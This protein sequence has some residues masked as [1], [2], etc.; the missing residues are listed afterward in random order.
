MVNYHIDILQEYVD[1]ELGSRERLELARH[2]GHNARDRGL[3]EAYQAQNEALQDVFGAKLH[4][5]VPEY[6][7]KLVRAGTSTGEAPAGRGGRWAG[8][9]EAKAAS[10]PH[11]AGKLKR[12]MAGVTDRFGDGAG[13]GYAG[14]DALVR[15]AVQSYDFYAGDEGRP[16]IYDGGRISDFFSWFEQQL[17]VRILQPDLGSVGFS[18]LQARFLPLGHGTGGQLLYQDAAERRLAIYFQVP[19]RPPG[20]ETVVRPGY[21][22]QDRL[23]VYHWQYDVVCYAM[24]AAMNHSELTRLARSVMR[25][26]PHSPTD[27]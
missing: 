18:V 4:E 2:L 25:Y 1:G 9:R 24:V 6:M 13:S 5:P 7:E 15:Q 17:K 21:I 20:R 8:I 12:A 19:D 14:I 3:V 27:S 23:A 22:Q 11:L 10:P 26:D 16:T